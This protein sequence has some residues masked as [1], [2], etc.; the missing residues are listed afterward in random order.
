MV[1]GF[2]GYGQ[3]GLGHTDSKVLQPGSTWIA[4]GPASPRAINHTC[5]L[6]NDGSLWCWGRNN[7]E[8]SADPRCL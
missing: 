4:N 8:H 3:L 7:V 6:E 5:A 1:L 2:N